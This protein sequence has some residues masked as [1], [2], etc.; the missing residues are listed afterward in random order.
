[1]LL[2]ARDCALRYTIHTM[3][4]FKSWVAKWMAETMGVKFLAQGSNKVGERPQ[5]G[6]KPGTS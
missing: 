4:Q 1:M 6:I 5:P 3:F 2:S